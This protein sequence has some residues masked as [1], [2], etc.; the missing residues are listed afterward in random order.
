MPFLRNVADH[1]RSRLHHEA[2]TPID[3]EAQ[4]AAV[5][6]SCETE[7]GRNPFLI[8]RAH[9][10]LRPSGGHWLYRVEPSLVLSPA[11]AFSFA[12][13]QGTRVQCKTF[14]W[15][16]SVDEAARPRGAFKRNSKIGDAR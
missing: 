11:A 2:P 7:G 3:Q 16:E 5:G 9:L 8:A 6:F 15:P 4:P 12:Y 14:N 1:E 13:H 10:R